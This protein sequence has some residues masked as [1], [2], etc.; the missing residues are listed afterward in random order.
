MDELK[1]FDIKIFAKTWDGVDPEA[2][3]GVFQRWIQEHTVPGILIDVAD[4]VHVHQGQG[5]VLVAHEYNLSI[6]YNGGAPGLLYRGKRPEG[7]TLAARIETGLRL[8][9]DACAKLEQEPEFAGKLAF[10]TTSF[11]FVTNDRLVVPDAA[12]AK[13]VEAAVKQAAEAVYSDGDASLEPIGDD[14][15]ERAAFRVTPAGQ[16]ATVSA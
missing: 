2:F 1:K 13:A 5:T 12:S 7:D 15:R 9:L 6:D 4:Y 10:D 16:P 8:A 14:P 11:A 3:M